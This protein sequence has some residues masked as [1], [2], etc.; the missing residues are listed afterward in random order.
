MN[1]LIQK[2]IRHLFKSRFPKNK[3]AGLFYNPARL[4]ILRTSDENLLPIE[5]RITAVV[6]HFPGISIAV[7]E[8]PAESAVAVAV[9][10]AGVSG[11]LPQLDVRLF[12]FI[13]ILIPVQ[14]SGTWETVPKKRNINCVEK[15]KKI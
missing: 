9:N 1:L 6:R 2:N 11:L 8:V 14:Y 7:A 5:D 13:V 15:R 3:R 12:V 4:F 10:G